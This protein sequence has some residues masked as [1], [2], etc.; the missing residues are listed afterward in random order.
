MTTR[1]EFE[2]RLS[3]QRQQAF[4]D[5][6]RSNVA[7]GAQVEA[8]TESLL[9]KRHEKRPASTA[10]PKRLDDIAPFVV[11]TSSGADIHPDA[12]NDIQNKFKS[13]ISEVRGRSAPD[14]QDAAEIRFRQALG[15]QVGGAPAPAPAPA[16]TKQTTDLRTKLLQLI[17]MGGEQPAAQPQ[18]AAPDQTITLA[19]GRKGIREE[20]PGTGTGLSRSIAPELLETRSAI[21]K[22]F[23]PQALPSVT[24]ASSYL[25]NIDTQGIGQLFAGMSVAAKKKLSKA[26]GKRTD[27]EK[28]IAQLKL[29]HPSFKPDEVIQLIQQKGGIGINERGTKNI[30]MYKDGKLRV[31]RNASPEELKRAI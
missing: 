1:R 21:E 20:L 17:G 29:V 18:A 24:K 23:F 26:L 12:P 4:P 2:K 22:F 28:A 13:L 11:P 27:E 14:Q 30:F 25:P 9:E 6:F 5:N 7:T 15:T 31:I 3:R 8:E 19:G 10:A 16:Q